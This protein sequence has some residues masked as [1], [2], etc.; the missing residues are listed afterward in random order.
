MDEQRIPK[1]II[2]HLYAKPN[3]RASQLLVAPD[4]SVTMRLKSP[5]QKGQANAV[6]LAFLT[7]V[8]GTN[9]SRVELLSVYTV[10]FKK[11]ALTDVDEQQLTTLLTRY[12]VS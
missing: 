4:G 11:V 7:E 3:A 10:P 1:P 6:L 8:F 12:H 2:L 5:S 9:K